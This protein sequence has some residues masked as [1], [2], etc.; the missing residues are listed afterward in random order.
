MRRDRAGAPFV[1]LPLLALATPGVLPAQD[2][3]F[4]RYRPRPG[5]VV[6]TVSWTAMTVTIGQRRADGFGAESLTVEVVEL[7]SLTE[8]PRGASAAGDH[9]V[10]ATY[11]SLRARMRPAGGAWHT[12]S[13]TTARSVDGV[14]LVDDFRRVARLELRDR[15]AAG[16]PYGRR[17]R[18]L[19]QRIT[20][21]LPEEPVAPGSQWT[22][23]LLYPFVPPAPLAEAIPTALDLRGFA[24]VGLDSVVVVP[25]DTLAFLRFDG[26]LA[27]PEPGDGVGTALRVTQLDASLA[28]SLVWSTGWSAYV[29]GATRM[30]LNVTL[31]QP[32]PGGVLEGME[33]GIDALY[34]FQVRP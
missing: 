10:E 6:H 4:L 28:G 26:V 12:V 13:D 33:V 20:L 22:A 8:T 15:S 21:S 29:S 11:D 27:R 32:T 2:S 3:L 14:L 19:A 30:L 1:L 25:G 34:R 7:E 24:A 18:S 9:V 5:A 31:L 16:Q 17:F 23:D